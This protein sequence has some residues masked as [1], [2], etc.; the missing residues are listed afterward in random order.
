MQ[1]DCAFFVKFRFKDFLVVIIR[2]FFTDSKIKE[3]NSITILWVVDEV[4]EN[5]YENCSKCK[6]I[7][8]ETVQKCHL[9]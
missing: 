8:R 3:F 6:K 2:C 1:Y 5:I 7:Q 4:S 9:I